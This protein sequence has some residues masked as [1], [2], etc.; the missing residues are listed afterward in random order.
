MAMASV[1]A[2]KTAFLP[3]SSNLHPLE[4]QT[5]SR[6][7]RLKSPPPCQSSVHRQ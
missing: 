5:Q 7:H 1:P 2:I 4:T 3:S 6:R